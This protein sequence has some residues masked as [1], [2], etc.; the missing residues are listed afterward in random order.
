MLQKSQTLDTPIGLGGS[1]GHPFKEL[2][3][4]ELPHFDSAAIRDG[5]HGGTADGAIC[6]CWRKGKNRFNNDVANSDTHT[7]WLQLKQTHK[8]CNKEVAPKKG[9]EG[10][11]RAANLIAC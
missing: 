10:T 1:H 9:E 7:R 8:L 11:I 5:F 2:V 6:C 3:M 4:E